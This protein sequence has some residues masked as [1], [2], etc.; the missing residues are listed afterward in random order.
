MTKHL[1]GPAVAFAIGIGIANACGVANAIPQNPQVRYE[2]SGPAVAENIYYQTDAGQLHQLNAPLPWST[3]FTAFGGQVF[4]IS[5]Q[6]P[7]PLICRI[8][9]NGT[10]VTHA[11]ATTGAPARTICTH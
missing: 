7:A 6:G 4:V 3:Q 11:T 9:L 1:S 2:V 5:A 8:L 10:E